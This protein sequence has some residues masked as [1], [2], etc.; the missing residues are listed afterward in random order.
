MGTFTKYLQA[1]DEIELIR[2]MGTVDKQVG[3]II[4]TDGPQTE[5]GE[6]CYIRI[7]TPGKE[8]LIPAEVQGFKDNKVILMPYE[9]IEGI[10]P[11]AEVIS[12]GGPLKINV[13]EE[14]LGRVINGIGKPLD[15]KEDIYTKTKKSIFNRPPS[16]LERK[17]ID[18]PLI[19]G[20]RAIDGFL[21]IGKGQ[22]MGIFA[23]AG[24]GKSTLLGMIARNALSDINVIAL[25]GERGREV[26]A[27]IEKDLGPKGLKRSIV[28]AATGDTSP[29]MQIRGAYVATTIAEYFRDLGADVTLL[30][31]SVTRL[32]RAQ[33]GVGLA[34]GEPPTTS[35]FTPSVFLMLPQLLE[36][37][38]TSKSGSITAFY[39]IL[40]EGDD[41]TEPVTDTVRAILDGHII[42]DRGLAHKNHYP[43]IDILGSV[44]RLMLDIASPEFNNAAGTI[45]KYMAIYKENEDLITIGAYPKGSDPDIDRAIALMPKVNDYLRQK[46][47]ETSSLKDTG[48]KL[49][50]LLTKR[51]LQGKMFNEQRDFPGLFKEKA[52][53]KDLKKSNSPSDDLRTA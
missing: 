46:I 43:A 17:T 41:F 19:T 5:K 20:I 35:G 38:G 10:Y 47:N 26:Q 50:R 30:F 21:S 3:L 16:P 45:R 18:K 40:V 27:F 33:R 48:E 39:S 4:E 31:D 49:F 1:V 51:E 9:D 24:V 11:G 7:Q 15:G 12:T 8:R 53:E 37:A 25:I 23:G 14:L 52:G 29:L 2:Y 13:S 32:A 42:L 6:F 36:R 44:S 28:V 22:R 34:A